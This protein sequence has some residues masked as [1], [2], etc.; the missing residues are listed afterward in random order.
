MLVLLRLD[1]EALLICSTGRHHPSAR[2][3]PVRGTRA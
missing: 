2:R 3:N 1:P